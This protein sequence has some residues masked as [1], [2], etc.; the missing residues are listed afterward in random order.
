MVLLFLVVRAFFNF[1]FLL[2]AEHRFFL[3][4]ISLPVLGR[5]FTG[6]KKKYLIHWLYLVTAIRTLCSQRIEML[7][8][9]QAELM[10]K[11]FVLQVT[12]LYGIEFSNFENHLLTHLTQQG[13]CCM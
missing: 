10:L 3:L 2:A 8:L 4:Y 1:F 6:N 7:E 11:V 13:E 5:Y 12:T 9:K